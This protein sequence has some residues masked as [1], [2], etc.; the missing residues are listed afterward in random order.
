MGVLRIPL[1]GGL[2][3]LLLFGCGGGGGTDASSLPTATLTQ[4][5]ANVALG[6][7]ASM[8]DTI[9]TI[10]RD[11]QETA[12][13]ARLA[14]GTSGSIACLVS[15]SIEWSLTDRDGSGTMTTGD[16]LRREYHDCVADTFGPRN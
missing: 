14:G 1:L 5:N 7:S 13:A 6:L 15:G 12:R 8:S 10:V 16:S 2:I 11:A 3:S 4:Q 9:F